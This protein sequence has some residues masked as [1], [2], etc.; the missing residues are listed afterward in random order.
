MLFVPSKVQAMDG[1]SFHSPYCVALQKRH[2]SIV[3]AWVPVTAPLIKGREVKILPRRNL[4][5]FY[6]SCIFNTICYF[7]MV[8]WHTE[9]HSGR[10]LKFMVL[11]ML[12]MVPACRFSLLKT[13]LIVLVV[14]VQLALGDGTHSFCLY[15]IKNP[16]CVADTNFYFYWQSR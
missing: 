15:L 6:C 4:T 5:L 8:C 1:T 7:H 2:K 10:G 3:C 12:T 13:W 11:F 9:E 16:A 14:S